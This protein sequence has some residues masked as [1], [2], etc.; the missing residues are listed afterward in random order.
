MLANSFP[1]VKGTSFIRALTELQRSNVFAPVTRGSGGVE[2][3]RKMLIE[4][5]AGVHEVMHDFGVFSLQHQGLVMHKG[6]L[7]KRFYPT[8]LVR[9]LGVG[10]LLTTMML[11]SGV[12]RREVASAS[13]PAQTGGIDAKGSSSSNARQT[14]YDRVESTP[15][16][17]NLSVVLG[18]PTGQLRSRRNVELRWL[19]DR[20][21]VDLG[22]ITEQPDAAQFVTIEPPVVGKFR[23]AS[24]RL[25]VFTPSAELLPAAT[26]FT[27]TL[28][29]LTAID[30]TTLS[31]PSILKFNTLPAIC[32]LVDIDLPQVRVSCTGSPVVAD[33]ASNTSLVLTPTNFDAAATQPTPE[34]LARM[35]AIDPNAKRDFQARLTQLANRKPIT[36]PLRYVDLGPCELD[37]PNGKTC[38]LFTT[39]G[40][41]PTDM[42]A[43]VK[44]ASGIRSLEGPLLGKTKTEGRVPLATSTFLDTTGCSADCEPSGFSIGTV[45][46]SIQPTG[47]DGLLQV[48]DL[49]TKRTTKYQL[50]P[51]S[52]DSD[53]PTNYEAPLS[54][55]WARLQPNHRYE[56]VL[57]KSA[58]GD[59]GLELGYTAVRTF[60]TGPLRNFL[61]LESGERV[62]EGSVKSVSVDVQNVLSFSQVVEK[63]KRED[64]V[65]SIRAF[66]QRGPKPIDFSSF[67]SISRTTQIKPNEQRSL[68][69]PFGTND[70][71]VFAIGIRS[72]T[73]VPKSEYR[74]TESAGDDSV[75]QSD[76]WSRALVQRGDL[77]VTVKR[78][79]SNVLVAVTSLATGAA[80]KD[81][82]VSLYGATD[83]A[84]WTGKTD[85][86]GLS[87][88]PVGK[89]NVCNIQVCDL[90][91]VAE[92]DGALG[93]GQ[94]YWRDWGDDSRVPIVDQSQDPTTI[95][96]EESGVVADAVVVQVPLLPKTDTA[97]QVV[98]SL[99]TDR[100]VYR[101]GEEIHLKGLV[102]IQTPT[103]LR[104]PDG[105]SETLAE[106]TDPR[107]N[108][109]GSVKLK[110]TDGAFDGIVKVPPDGTQ[111]RYLI[112]AAGLTT[113]FLVTS[114]RKPDFV[115][116]AK[117]RR[118]S[119]ARGETARF[120][121][122]AKYLFGA[123]MSGAS[124]EGV[125][126]ASRAYV[127]PVAGQTDQALAELSTMA[128]DY[129]C[130]GYDYENDS[131]ECSEVG[132]DLQSSH[133][134]TM[135]DLGQR[136][137]IKALPVRKTRHRPAELTYEA[138]V[139]DV[140]RQAF[141]DRGSTTI[142]PGA[143]YVGVR[144]VGSLTDVNEPLNVE[145][146]A[147]GVNGKALA[148]PVTV[149]VSL[150]RW[151]YLSTNKANADGSTSRVGGWESTLEEERQLTVGSKALAVAF[152]PKKAGSYEVR[153]VSNDERG[154]Y[155][156]AGIEAYV[157]GPGYVA[158][159]ESSEDPSVKLIADKTSYAPGEVARVLVQ[160]PW[161]KAEGLLTVE[162]NGVLSAK[163]F[164]VESSAAAIDIPIADEYA[165]NV[166]AAVTLFKGR[167][168]PPTT[169]NRSDPG[170][171]QVMA[172]SIELSVPPTKQKLQVGIITDSRTYRPGADATANVYLKDQGGKR[173]SGE[174]TLWAVDEGVLRLTGYQ[175]PSILNDMYP[176]RSLEVETADSRMR[177]L[178]QSADDE[179]GGETN[180]PN[181]EPGGGGG[182]SDANGEGVRS[183][184]RL[185]A[186]WSG[187][188]I[189]GASGKAVVAMKLPDSLTQF[190]LIAVA[191][192]G[193]EQFGSTTRSV[194]VR[195]PL[196]LL[197]SLPRFVTPGDE[198]EAGAVVHNDTGI[199]GNTTVSLA[200]DANSPVE[201]VGPPSFTIPT[202]DSTA[203]EVRF[204]LKAVRLGTANF[205]LRAKLV[206]D[207]ALETASSSTAVAAAVKPTAGVGPLSEA[208]LS[209]AVV[210]NVP[211]T[212]T[213]RYETVVAVGSTTAGSAP[214]IEQLSV[215][216]NASKELGELTITSASSTLAGLQTGIASLVEYPYG[217]LEQ[218]SSRIRVLMD[219]TELADTYPLPGIAAGSLRKRVQSELVKLNDY[220]AP[221]GGG[222]TY[223]PGGQNP[224]PY[225]SARVLILLDDAKSHGY[226]I[227]T[228]LDTDLAGWISQAVS[229]LNNSDVDSSYRP[230]R[231]QFAWAAAVAG[232]PE[233]GLVKVLTAQ[234][235]DLSFLEQTHLLRA[236]LEAGDVG[237]EPNYL[238][239]SL[240]AGVRID[241]NEASVQ[242]S[243]NWSEWSNL[244][245]LDGGSVHDTAALLS[246]I[247]RIDPKHPLVPK[248][249]RWLLRQRNNGA[250]NNT[251]E[252]GYALSALLD[253]A[254]TSEPATPNFTAAISLGATELLTQ[255]F[256]GRSLDV[257]ST[258]VPMGKVTQAAAGAKAPL[259]FSATGTGTFQWEAR[260]R[261]A[262]QLSTLKA[263]DQGFTVER[264]YSPYSALLPTRAAIVAAANAGS[265]AVASTTSYVDGSIPAEGSPGLSGETSFKAGDLVIVRLRI[266]TAEVRR[267]VVVDDPL[268][269][270]LEALNTLLT[271]TSQAEGAAEDTSSV[272]HT[273]IKNDRVLMFATVLPN[274]STVLQYVAR[275][276]TPGSFT[277]PPAQVEDMY[278]SEVFGRTATTKFIVRP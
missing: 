192:S 8:S 212:V 59:D 77:A 181:G 84:Y 104:M 113:D 132:K 171:P 134:L 162:R 188:V 133:R 127:N 49:G 175:T 272:D 195:K 96:D 154:N 182:E 263:L 246:L 101:L 6:R 28:Q 189:V 54:L 116:D 226:T 29:G 56:L 35:V 165:P 204:R 99:F 149:T 33:V 202:A 244:S 60:S 173:I 16:S 168:S 10:V 206:T 136:K 193:A 248:M 115:V 274:G 70:S 139:F 1:S 108:V 156:E 256:A 205:T 184:F 75:D 190:R 119:Y 242:E 100:G 257:V 196:L 5:R 241:G 36:A 89:D 267:N 20:P 153:I 32:S 250:W 41:L 252:S 121:V 198:F 176:Y 269:A 210:A 194:T 157:M 111:G 18:A 3:L 243:Y 223:W 172:G 7:I 237:K 74:G 148:K 44:F 65:S 95:P 140:S 224:D 2:V 235:N 219:L 57:K 238:F 273:E 11:A 14:S 170:R 213:Q 255:K 131:D 106:I 50:P 17:A 216:S 191:A 214:S 208:D 22:G 73:F 218:R 91:A 105:F 178:A 40:A 124:M 249:T 79:P 81:V 43:A 128:W 114:F 150:L 229:D 94:S 277:V 260:L 25:L 201:V 147:V 80:I 103:T 98:G 42:T 31:S 164:T 92:K 90:I 122:D 126:N 258:P 23:W 30:G 78:S 129:V 93:Y 85:S 155:L 53:T 46:P 61:S 199:A 39:T 251:L 142:H 232:K 24:T 62:V 27:A 38:F 177:L 247:T 174:V 82:K 143:Y 135:S 21:V 13:L 120:Q 245:Y 161:V 158:W 236:M 112:R 117:A 209:D 222:L 130:F 152:S 253:V 71:G 268:P 179:K 187:R 203:Q 166:F 169:T 15:S 230:T 138:N 47:A 215:P 266:T 4:C 160:S 48:T 64:L 102:R 37:A 217:C 234:Q 67:D 107:D 141:A 144:Q 52:T 63:I 151:E 87:T 86:S 159:Y 276:T 26:V 180:G 254:R 197:P 231:A 227:P 163:R 262:P 261:Y 109:V 200:I 125:Y 265:S 83:T 45:G 264:S 9:S 220:R 228:G 240:L 110:V 270:G 118:Q 183:D 167:T 186:A 207:T 34:D 51:D 55:A 58:K 19:F 233:R 69:I 137:P 211:V 259:A 76:R 97:E 68:S 123:P 146:A 185:L 72:E 12:G 271:S 225:L 66:N 278:R 88:G 145:V 275:A 239:T 221:Y